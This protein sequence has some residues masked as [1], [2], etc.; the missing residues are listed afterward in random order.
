MGRFFHVL[1]D[2]N[3]AGHWT[4]SLGAQVRNL[5]LFERLYVSLGGGLKWLLEA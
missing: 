5:P 2:K 3:T 4:A 1:E